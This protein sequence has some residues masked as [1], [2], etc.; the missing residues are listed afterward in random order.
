MITPPYSPAI[1]CAHRTLNGI[2]F[3]II[4]TNFLIIIY[5]VVAENNLP[6]SVVFIISTTCNVVSLIMLLTY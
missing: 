5:G 4:F 2:C 6:Q 3:Q 1:K